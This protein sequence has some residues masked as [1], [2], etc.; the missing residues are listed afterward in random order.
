VPPNQPL[1]STV[2]LPLGPDGGLRLAAVADTHSSPHPALS[3]HLRSLRPDAILH[4]GD[5]GDL[6][7]LDA[8]AEVAPV[9]AVRGNIDERTPGLADILTLELCAA[10][11]PVVRALLTHIAVYGPKLRAEVARLARERRAS[12]VVCGHSHVPFIGSD[13]GLFVF[14]PGSAGPRRFRLPI[15]FGLIEAGPGGIELSH[16]DCE[17]G[18]PWSP[19]AFRRP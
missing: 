14:N 2:A 12:L 6:S 9:F 18:E 1:E 5:I 17:T 4:A 15:L 10:G 11:I 7:V 16:V 3:G 19:P 8:L 13:R